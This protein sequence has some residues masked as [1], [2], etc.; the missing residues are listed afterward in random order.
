MH[1]FFPAL[2]FVSSVGK[3]MTDDDSRWDE[4]A[5]VW[6]SAWPAIENWT[7]LVLANRPRVVPPPSKPQ[8][9]ICTDAS[10]WGWGYVAL[11]ESSGRVR[12]FGARWSASVRH[13]HGDKLGHS[14]YA[15]PMAITNAFCHLFSSS[16]AVPARVLV[17]TDNSAARASFARGFNSRS[18]EINRALTRFRERF[19]GVVAEFIHVPGVSNVAD[20][21]SRGAVGKVS[22]QEMGVMLRSV[23]G[24]ELAAAQ[25]GVGASPANGF[26]GD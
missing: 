11:E 3:R 1:R 8:W 21:L 19:P 14:V 16:E 24:L 10:R 5:E 26:V 2:A 7:E 13:L 23:M 6:D 4:P 12:S 18:F 15:E 9:L 25:Q 20:S 22:D 17:G